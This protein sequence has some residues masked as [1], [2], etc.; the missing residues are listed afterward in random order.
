M[1]LARPSSHG[2][3]S[4]PVDPSFAPLFGTSSAGSE[5]RDVLFSDSRRVECEGPWESLPEC[6][7]QD[8]S[9]RRSI[10]L[11]GLS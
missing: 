3:G 4:S 9:D 7:W 1:F 2:D 11:E 8:N 10:G 5:L 6:A